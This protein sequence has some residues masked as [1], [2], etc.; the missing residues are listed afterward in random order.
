[1][2]DRTDSERDKGFR[3]PWETEDSEGDAEVFT[4]P[5]TERP[6]PSDVDL[7][8]WDAMT[9]DNGALEDYTAEDYAAATTE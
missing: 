9:S 2:S 3:R 1:M 6:A 8:D 4:L 5:D 7:T